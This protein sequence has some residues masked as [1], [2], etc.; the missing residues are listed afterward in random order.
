[1]NEATKIIYDNLYENHD[2]AALRSELTLYLKSLL[3][4]LADNPELT[5]QIA[6]TI[7]GMMA[8]D[9]ARS[10]Q[11]DDPLAEIMT[12]A[13]ELETSPNNASELTHELAQKIRVL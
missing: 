5:P 10:L 3:S 4:I 9:Y 8:T 12:I 11:D 6:Y 7:A 2:A 13:G 1:M